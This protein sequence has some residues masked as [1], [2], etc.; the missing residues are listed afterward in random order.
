MIFCTRCVYPANHPLNITFDAQG[1]CSGC[2]VHE[3]KD[4]LDWG[5]R[6]EELKKITDACRNTSGRNYDCVVRGIRIL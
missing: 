2:R 6:F 1:V 4:T 5:A 3:E